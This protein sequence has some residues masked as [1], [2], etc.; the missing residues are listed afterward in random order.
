MK[1]D[2]PNKSESL[3][4]LLKR[5]EITYKFIDENSP[6]DKSLTPEIKKTG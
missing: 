6:S 1:Y 4:Q 2:E 5:P 3:E